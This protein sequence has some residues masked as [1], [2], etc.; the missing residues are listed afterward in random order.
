MAWNIGDTGFGMKLTL[1]VP[2][3]VKD[4]IAKILDVLL[5]RASK[6]KEDIKIW[7][8]HPGGKAF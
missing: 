5:E 3:V 2:R 6:T 8:I 1:N 4:N 7:A